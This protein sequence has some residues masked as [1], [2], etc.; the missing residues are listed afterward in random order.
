MV[1]SNANANE[2]VATRVF[3]APRE[4]VWQVWTDPKH[5]AEWWGP[6]GFRNT[7]QKMDVRSGGEWNFIMHGP[8]GT[9]YQNKFVY[10]EVVKPERIVYDHVSGPLFHAVAT[11]EPQGDKTAVTV[12]MQFES[13]E[14]RDKVAKEF[15]AVEGLNQTL[16][17]LGEKL[18]TIADEFVISRTFDAP[19]DLMW[20]VWTE[21]EHMQHWFGPKGTTIVYNN[22]DFRAGGTYHYA[23]RTSD[24]G[25]MWGRWVYREITPPARLVFVNSFSD[26]DGGLT[27]HPFAPDWPIEMLSTIEFDESDGKTSVTIRWSPL[28]ATEAERKAFAA[29]HE[30]MKM[31]W[32]GTF[33]QLADYLGRMK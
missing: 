33:D 1:A 8:D 17:R 31:G 26:K 6:R 15:G 21:P 7:I 30:G 9:D 10:V 11:F 13:A 23:M 19:R 27:R 28:N 2:I 4:L 12:R 14:L 20:K 25:E 32:G 5:I 29:G 16:D 22:N 3:D 24:G 18:A